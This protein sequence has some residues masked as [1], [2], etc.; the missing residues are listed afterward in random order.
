[1]AKRQRLV[2]VPSDEVQ[3]AGSW[4]IIAR[5]TVREARA[6]QKATKQ[7]DYDAF[8][9]GIEVL[10]SHVREWNWVDDDDTPLAQPKDCP[11]VVEG[12][13]MLEVTFLSE[14]IKGSEEDAK[15]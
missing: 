10:R 7:K 12:L 2:R 6:A 3:G 14:A 13:T 8:E 11:D 1:M 4:V 9:F 15:N 5:T